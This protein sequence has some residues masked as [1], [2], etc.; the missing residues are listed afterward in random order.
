MRT[1]PFLIL[2]FVAAPRAWGSQAPGA[3]VVDPS[4]ALAAP[5]DEGA[6]APRDPGASKIPTP[7]GPSCCPPPSPSPRAAFP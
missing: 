3:P 1:V 6:G 7:T 2:V 5:A 4:L